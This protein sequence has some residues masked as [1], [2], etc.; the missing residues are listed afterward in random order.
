MNGRLFIG[1]VLIVITGCASASNVPQTQPV[2]VSSPTI[3]PTR[4]LILAVTSTPIPFPTSTPSITPMASITPQPGF[5]IW[6]AGSI[7][8]AYTVQF[9]EDKWT[10]DSTVLTHKT[11]ERCSVRLHGGSDICMSGG[12]EY[13]GIILGDAGFS[14]TIIGEGMAI[15]VSQAVRYWISYEIMAE[16]QPKKCLHE[17]E[18]VLATI[19]LRPEQACSDRAEFVEDVTIP[20]NTSIPAGTTFTKTW[21]VKNT[22]TCTWTHEYSLYL[23]GRIPG[24]DFYQKLKLEENVSPNQIIDIS[25][26]LTAPSIQGI[27]RWEWML[28]NEFE[29]LFGVGKRSYTQMPGDPLWVQIVVGP[30]PFPPG[31]NLWS[32]E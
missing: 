6:D 23:V 8:G 2:N 19:L 24:A 29:D 7:V 10:E 9:P 12:C 4:I 27:A 26:E 28:Q 22:G 30:A 25:V 3:L 13:T 32:R 31:K 15:Y 16:E 11:L 14:K 17:G 20:D 1:I 18:E 21:R 5:D